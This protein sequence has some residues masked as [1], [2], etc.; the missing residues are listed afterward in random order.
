M[1][2]Q[3]LDRSNCFAY[4]CRT[5]SSLSLAINTLPVSVGLWLEG[6]LGVGGGGER[7]VGVYASV[8]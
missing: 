6:E 1:T 3:N 7:W 4:R 5:V 8:A 2:P